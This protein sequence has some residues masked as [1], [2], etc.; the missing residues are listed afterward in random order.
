MKC[1]VSLEI[2]N[3]YLDGELD[4][5]KT[6][7]IEQHIKE[8]SSCQRELDTLRQVDKLIR[9]VEVAGPSRDF[10]F[11][12]NRKVME[13]VRK[14]G[15]FSL[16]KYA[17]ILVPVAVTVLVLVI[18]MNAPH[19]VRLVS[20]DDQ[21]MYTEVDMKEDI[22][23]TIPVLSRGG[24]AEVEEPKAGRER[25]MAK[26]ESSVPEPVPCVAAP[27][28]KAAEK[29][30]DNDR[31]DVP[32]KGKA[33][34]V[35]TEIADEMVSS[36]ELGEG[37]VIPQDRVVRAIVDSNGQILKVATG[38]TIIPEQDTMLENQFMGQQVA[39]PSVAGKR[40]QLYVDFT[41]EAETTES[42]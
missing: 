36:S 27:T 26:K 31:Y 19:P 42:K 4:P 34:D 29:D 7:E 10:I 8:C 13:R 35:R 22:E 3:G 12:V 24:Y 21:V 32:A 38:N 11:G 33:A 5:D 30:Y 9:N 25:V 17:S 1:D 2:L 28:E 15:R 23:V 41:Q 20:M 14:Q 18:V 37:L 16:F 40:Q 6:R 39:P